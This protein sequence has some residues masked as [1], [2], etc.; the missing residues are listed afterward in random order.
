M[1]PR[2]SCAGSRS[3]RTPPQGWEGLE[4]E[5]GSRENENNSLSHETM[6]RKGIRVL[7][8]PTN[9]CEVDE[10]VPGWRL[11][12]VHP[13][14]VEPCVPGADVAQAQ[15]GREG[16]GAELGAGAQALRVGPDVG[17]GDAPVVANVHA[18]KGKKDTFKR[19]PVKKWKKG[20][21]G[22]RTEGVS[23]ISRPLPQPFFL[24]VLAF[25]NS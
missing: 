7:V 5:K 25:N 21:W 18:A 8:V 2:K 23:N 4:E 6:T 3:R 1:A 22:G 9:D 15:Q 13:A 12:E 16:L 24:P 10:R 17:R 20:K 11:G 19:C 14:P